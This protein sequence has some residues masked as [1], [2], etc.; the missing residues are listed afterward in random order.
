MSQSVPK[1]A[2]H[3]I[4]YKLNDIPRNSGFQ[5]AISEITYNVTYKKTTNSG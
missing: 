3:V 4:L 2:P 5:E 1:V